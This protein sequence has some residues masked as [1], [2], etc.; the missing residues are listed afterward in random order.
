MCPDKIISNYLKSFNY[1][2]EN[3]SANMSS[4]ISISFYD[5]DNLNHSKSLKESLLKK[6]ESIILIN[7]NY[8]EYKTK[9][10]RFVKDS[11]KLVVKPRKSI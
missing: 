10:L 11:N 2:K 8:I 4:L 6:T 7:T 9:T 3:T 1:I 5:F